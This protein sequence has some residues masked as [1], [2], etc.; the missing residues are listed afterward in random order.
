MHADFLN[1]FHA[2]LSGNL[3]REVLVFAERLSEGRLTPQYQSVH[4]EYNEL[5]LHEALFGDSSRLADRLLALIVH[6][7]EEVQIQACKVI[8]SIQ[9]S[10]EEAATISTAQRVQ[11]S[12]FD[13]DEEDLCES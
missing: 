13:T 7:E 12:F 10:K 8:L 6:P 2:S 4:W 9:L 3:L 5:S 1:L 11:S